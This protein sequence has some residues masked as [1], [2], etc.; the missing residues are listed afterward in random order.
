VCDACG[1]KY[2]KKGDQVIQ[3]DSD[4]RNTR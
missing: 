1:A 2:E 3:K 4:S